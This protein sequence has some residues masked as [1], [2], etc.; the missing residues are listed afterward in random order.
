MKSNPAVPLAEVEVLERARLPA[1]A[2]ISQAVVV[3]GLEH[4]SVPCQRALLRTF[5]EG[6]I[7]LDEDDG[8][9]SFAKDLPP[10][11]FVVYVCPWNPRERPKIHKSLVRIPTIINCTNDQLF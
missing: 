6:R 9:E 4:A 10:D 11:F 2:E 5:L 8:P 1:D 7:A 3:S